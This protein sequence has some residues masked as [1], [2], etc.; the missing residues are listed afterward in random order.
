MSGRPTRLPPHSENNSLST[1]SLRDDAA[2][3]TG[4]GD[5]GRPVTTNA[6]ARPSGTVSATRAGAAGGATRPAAAGGAARPTGASGAARPTTDTQ[7]NGSVGKRKLLAASLKVVE[8]NRGK[9]RRSDQPRAG[10]ARQ[11]PGVGAAPDEAQRD[12]VKTFYVNL[13][14]IDGVRDLQESL[15][16]YK[17][18]IVSSYANQLDEEKRDAHRK[19]W[20]RLNRTATAFRTRSRASNNVLP[21]VPKA[22]AVPSSSKFKID[23][24]AA[25]RII[26]RQARVKAVARHSSQKNEL[27][28]PARRISLTEHQSSSMQKKLQ[29]LQ[30]D[31]NDEILITHSLKCQAESTALVWNESFRVEAPLPLPLS[32]RLDRV[33]TPTDSQLGKDREAHKRHRR[34]TLGH[35]ERIGTGLAA[36]GGPEPERAVITTSWCERGGMRACA[37]R[38]DLA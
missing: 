35:L 31:F 17:L 10:A 33:A 24:N 37:A 22:N 32:L 15:A 9:S 26:Q 27:E 29:G 8:A 11:N 23:E 20:G 5:A 25:A 28:T 21:L 3:S 14:G 38:A 34:S 18:S 12:R 16:G 4:T 36:I 1:L 2:Q 7:S 30:R 19:K 13:G 6:A